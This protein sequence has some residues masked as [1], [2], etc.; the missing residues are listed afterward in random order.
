M[1]YSAVEA[2]LGIAGGGIAGIGGG[3]GGATVGIG[4]TSMGDGGG[5]QFSFSLTALNLLRAAAILALCS[6]VL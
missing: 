1:T 4:G 3:S 5:V 6:I 2:A